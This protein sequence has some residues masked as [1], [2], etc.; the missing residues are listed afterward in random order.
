[1]SQGNWDFLVEERKKKDKEV[2]GKLR[3]EEEAL[4]KGQEVGHM[5]VT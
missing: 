2:D 5:H 1:M 3:Q 4:R